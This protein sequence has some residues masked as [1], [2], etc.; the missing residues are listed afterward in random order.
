[1]RRRATRAWRRA[2]CGAWLLLAVPALGGCAQPVGPNGRGDPLEPMNR[3]VFWFNERVD[4]YVLEPVATGWDWV[5][6]DR[7]QEAV[8]DFFA[9]LRFPINLVNDL[10]QGKPRRAAVDTGRF[11]VNTTL[12]LAGFF[13]L[14]ADFGL[15]RRDEDFGQT[16][17]WWGVGFGPYIVLPLLGPS[18]PRDIAGMPLDGALAV[19]P[20]FVDWW[21]S[22]S[23]RGVYLVNWRSTVLDEIAQERRDAFDYYAF[24]RNA[25]FQ[26]RQR[27]VE[28]GEEAE[29]APSGD[30]LYHP[31]DEE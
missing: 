11:L 13:D 18:S 22:A 17:G 28:D 4:R 1:M 12:G 31:E 20:F 16:L 10:L 26:Y 5:L 29:Q 23:A 27:Q 19:Y 25:Y 8:G 9:N 3:G 24:V 14:A 21:V 15:Q 2:A 30:D 6:P 7:V